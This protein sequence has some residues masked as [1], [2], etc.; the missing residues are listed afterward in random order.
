MDF[1]ER[2]ATPS[3]KHDQCFACSTFYM[4]AIVDDNG[5]LA[6]CLNGKIVSV[7]FTEIA[8][9]LKNLVID[10]GLQFEFF[11]TTRPYN[12]GTVKDILEYEGI[13]LPCTL[14]KAI[15]FDARAKQLIPAINKW[16][17]TEEFVPQYKYHVW[18]FDEVWRIL[19]INKIPFTQG[20]S[21]SLLKCMY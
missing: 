6:Y 3:I 4:S 17:M 14:P 10:L 8:S 13:E 12:W 16:R 5:F 11:P 7:T 21:G 9:E 1:Q 2:Y 18:S 15:R 19:Y 20:W